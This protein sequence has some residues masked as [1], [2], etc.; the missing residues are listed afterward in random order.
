MA[1]QL[2][3]YKAR[4]TGI[5][6]SLEQATQKQ[7]EGHVDRQIAEKFNVLLK[8]LGGTFPD[9]APHLP[10]PITFGTDIATILGS[11]DATYLALHIMVEQV[12]QLLSVVE[13]QG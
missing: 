8:E 13:S 1:S 6:T 3:F 10:A 9:L 4:L 7:K 2:R 11:S 5:K 12:L